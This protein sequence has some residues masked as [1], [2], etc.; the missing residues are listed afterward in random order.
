MSPKLSREDRSARISSVRKQNHE[1]SLYDR[2]RSQDGRR[3][4][5]GGI[6]LAFRRPQS[7]FL[8]ASFRLGGIDASASYRVEDADAGTTT[9]LGGR[10]LTGSGLRVAMDKRP[11]S[12]LFFYTRVDSM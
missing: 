8:S 1:D 3:L 2:Q 12:R 9:V 6:I 7:P 11:D 5:R 10:E 4:D